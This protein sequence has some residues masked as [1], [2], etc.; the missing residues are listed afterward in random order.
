MPNP[1]LKYNFSKLKADGGNAQIEDLFGNNHILVCADYTHTRA[2]ECAGIGHANKSNL[3]PL[4]VFL[5]TPL[6]GTTEYTVLRYQ[7]SGL[8]NIDL[9]ENNEISIHMILDLNF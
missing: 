3:N 6:T 9:R 1:I 8:N 5:N 4:P 7:R 2:K